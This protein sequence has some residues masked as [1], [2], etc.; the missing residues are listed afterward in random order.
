MA[1]AN[2]AE[3]ACHVGNMVK[4]TNQSQLNIV[5]DLMSNPVGC[6]PIGYGFHLIHSYLVRSTDIR[7]TCVLVIIKVM[8]GFKV[9]PLVWSIFI[10]Q[11]IDLTSGRF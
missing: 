1:G 6:K 11:T 10:L 8:L 7:S 5:A 4:R 3:L 2:L 9:F